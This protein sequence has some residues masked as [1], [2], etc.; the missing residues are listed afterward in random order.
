VLAGAL[1]SQSFLGRT[2][3]YAAKVD[4]ALDAVTVGEANRVLRKYVRAD[5][6]AWS[7][8]GEFAKAK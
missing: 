4:A 5:G 3:D 7:A 2:W 8:A 1:V 6:F